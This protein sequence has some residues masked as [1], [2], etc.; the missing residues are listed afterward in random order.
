MEPN[1][2]LRHT[3]HVF[4]VG[5]L[6]FVAIVGL[7]LGRSLFV[8]DTFGQHGFYR[9]ANVAEQMDYT[10][11]HGGHASCQVCHEEE[12]E[13]HA[14]GGHRTVACE[15]CHAPLILHARDGEKI[16]DMPVRRS[17]ELCL[18]CHQQ[19][20]ARRADFPQIQP[21]QHLEENDG[22]P[23]PESCFECHEPHSPL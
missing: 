11:R 10:P 19:L 23:G 4:R 7:I 3:K 5:L 18:L 15:S 6:L 14:D 22:T 17:E 12:A 1:S 20:K 13:E 2:P 9:G 8:P 21:R 16:A